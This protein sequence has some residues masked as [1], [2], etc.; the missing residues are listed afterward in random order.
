MSS[1]AEEAHDLAVLAGLAEELVHGHL[2]LAVDVDGR[3]AVVVAPSVA[4]QLH[5]LVREM[6]RRARRME[7]RT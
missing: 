1:H 6:A 5:L 2:S 7:E 3:P 4:S